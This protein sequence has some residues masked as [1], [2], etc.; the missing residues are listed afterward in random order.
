M[1]LREENTNLVPVPGLPKVLTSLT[2]RSHPV[3]VCV[4]MELVSSRFRRC[5]IL[6]KALRISWVRQN[7][8]VVSHCLNVRHVNSD[9]KFPI[10]SL[11]VDDIKAL[12]DIE[13]L[14]AHAYFYFDSRNAEKG[15]SL[16]HNFVRSLLTQLAY[17]CKGIP[18]AL[19]NLYGKHG[20]GREQTSLTA[21]HET[22]QRIMEGFDHVYIV[23]DSLDECGDRPEL[24]RHLTTAK[25][26][27][28]S[29][30]HLLLISRPE[31]SIQT[32]LQRTSPFKSVTITA[33]VS[34][35][36]IETFLDAR[37]S[38]IEHWSQDIRDAVRKKLKN[39]GGMYV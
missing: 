22:L 17:R 24:L 8:H 21:L 29:N 3:H 39:A 4:C 38:N 33:S 13:P 19:Q 34:Q 36:D 6:T 2:G 32:R 1:L 20:D 31:P 23:V 5:F 10:S 25:V 27:E 16:Y 18:A 15:L 7:H 30:L 37:L 9:S 35:K 12:Q 14:S 11:M 28:S 26:W